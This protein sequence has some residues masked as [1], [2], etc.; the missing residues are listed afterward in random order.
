MKSILVLLAALFS[1]NAFAVSFGPGPA[2]PGRFTCD[3]S[4]ESGEVDAVMVVDIN[5][6]MT[7]HPDDWAAT[8]TV[9]GKKTR[10][11]KVPTVYAW[12]EEANDPEVVYGIDSVQGLFPWF[13]YADLGELTSGY[14]SVNY[15]VLPAQLTFTVFYGGND[16][17]VPLTCDIEYVEPPQASEPI[18]SNAGPA[19]ECYQG[20]GDDRYDLIY[21]LGDM[22]I[23]HTNDADETELI[24]YDSARYYPETETISGGRYILNFG[25]AGHDVDRFDVD[26]SLFK[27]NGD[28]KVLLSNIM[29][30]QYADTY[31]T[32]D[33]VRE[34]L[35]RFN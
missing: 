25:G 22:A 9:V 14:F 3:L 7:D 27:L 15:G 21:A 29:E 17:E 19:F 6:G 31:E 8:Y 33:W 5:H 2:K 28:K 24:Y 1:V 26:A 18:P 16:I 12:I 34:R 13:G 11:I 35:N 32:D 23:V 30:C 10:D 20:D 4:Q